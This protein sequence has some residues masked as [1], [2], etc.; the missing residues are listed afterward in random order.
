LFF[1]WILAF[2]T[3]D[4]SVRSEDTALLARGQIKPSLIQLAPGE[5][6][7]FKVVL[8]PRRLQP[9]QVSGKV[10]WAVNDIPGGNAQLGTIDKQGVYQAPK[11][12]PQP[13][14]VHICAR[15]EEAANS[16]LWATVILGTDPPKYE[17]VSKWEEP[18]D[19][20]AHLKNPSDIAIEQDGNLLITDDGCSQVFR[21]TPSGEFLGTIGL[22]SGFD[23]GKFDKPHNVAVDD[24][25]KIFVSDLRTGPP[26]IQVFGHDGKLLHA[27]GQKGAGP[28]QVMETRGMEFDPAGRLLVADIENMRVNLYSHE[29]DF[30]ETWQRDGIRPGEFNLPYGVVVDR[31]GDVFVPGYYG[32]CQK[33]DGQGNFLFAFAHPDPPDGPVAY[34]SA[35]GDRWGNVYLAV[36]DS[37]GL[38]QNSVDPEPKLVRFLKFNNNGDL[39]TSFPLWDDER[40]EN[41][42]VVDENG[43]LHIL[44]RRTEQVGVATF[45]ER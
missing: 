27:F 21:Y 5:Q 44:F 15:A 31:N 19:G 32:P 39:V 11:A 10:S 29:G 30:I 4:F 35:T 3:F 12:V 33:F 2:S 14:E 34:T 26:R 9:A 1:T 24:Q 22:G 37:A 40:G 38:V 20:S 16:F 17:M 28:G 6:C 42:A 23:P 25:G 13:C 8:A 41:G 18:A 43:R 45:E 36:R 7:Q